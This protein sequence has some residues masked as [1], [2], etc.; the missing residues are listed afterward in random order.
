M[1]LTKDQRERIAAETARIGQDVFCAAVRNSPIEMTRTDARVAI[2]EAGVAAGV[3]ELHEHPLR[4]VHTETQL[5]ETVPLKRIAE[6]LATARVR[7]S[8]QDAMLINLRARL[9]QAE[10]LLKQRDGK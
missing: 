4:L 6:E 8:N 10:T 9:A 5:A 2:F 3:R 1:A 7:I